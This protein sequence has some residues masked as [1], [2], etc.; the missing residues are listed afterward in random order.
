MPLE[1]QTGK[2]RKK[3]TTEIDDRRIKKLC[4]GNKK[5]SSGCMQCKMAQANVMLSTS[6]ARRRLKG[7]DLNGR[8]PRKKL[9]TL[10]FKRKCI[11]YLLVDFL[12]L[13]KNNFI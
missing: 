7:F 13:Q 11:P 6:P 2:H 8:I 4:I 12:R 10:L 9:L 3:C 1:N 5:K